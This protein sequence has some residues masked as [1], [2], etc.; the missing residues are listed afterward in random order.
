MAAASI[1][2]L[3]LDKKSHQKNTKTMRSHINIGTGVDITIQELAECIKNILGY[4]GDIS[5]DHSKPDGPP[6]KL[7]DVKLLAKIGWRSKIGL[8]D[9]IKRTYEKYLLSLTNKHH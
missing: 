7:I 5:F 8:E 4:E 2:V 9:G 3:E 1:F 6:R